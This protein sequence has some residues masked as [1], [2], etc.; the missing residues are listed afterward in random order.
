[1]SSIRN[2]KI[3]VKIRNFLNG[4]MLFSI[5]G[6]IITLLIFLHEPPKKYVGT[7]IEVSAWSGN[8]TIKTKTKIGKD[9]LMEVHK[10]H[11]EV[12]AIGQTITV[13]TGGDLFSGIATTKPQN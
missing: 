4:L 5:I 12:F 8:A 7:V 11:N 6:G 3:K 13:W 9:T 1:M 2:S 10:Q